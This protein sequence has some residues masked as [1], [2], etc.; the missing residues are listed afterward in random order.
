M[1][2]IPPLEG[3]YRFEYKMKNL[4]IYSKKWYTYGRSLIDKIIYSITKKPKH[5]VEVKNPPKTAQ[6]K[7]A[8]PQDVGIL[9][10]GEYPSSP[11]CG[12]FGS[13]FHSGRGFALSLFTAYFPKKLI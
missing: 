10:E 2:I 12:W 5:Y 11:R 6:E 7:L 4:D 3:S 13:F 8:R 9:A 1:D